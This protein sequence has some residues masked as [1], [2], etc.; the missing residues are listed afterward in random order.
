[1]QSLGYSKQTNWT[2]YTNAIKCIVLLYYI[3]MQLNNFPFLK[4]TH[5]YS[6]YQQND[7]RVVHLPHQQ[8][9]VHHLLGLQFTQIYLFKFFIALLIGFLF[10]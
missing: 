4:M 8:Q 6:L 2:K 10:Q 1:M 7:Q 9:V 3:V 5:F